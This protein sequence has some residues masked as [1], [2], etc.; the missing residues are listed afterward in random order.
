MTSDTSGRRQGRQLPTTEQ[1]RIW[2]DYIETAEALR[3]ALATRLQAEC[4]LSPGDYVVL[5]A[6]SEAPDHRMRSSEL[7]AHDS[8]RDSGRVARPSTRRRGDR[9]S[10]DR[11]FHIT[12]GAM[13]AHLDHGSVSGVQI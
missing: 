5:L 12:V 13:T 3:T 7:A 10:Q 1:L 9:S 8:G 2:R 6:L 11:Q 4:S